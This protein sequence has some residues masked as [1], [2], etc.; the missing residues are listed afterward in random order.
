M[1]TLSLRSFAE[2]AA[3]YRAAGLLGTF[4]LPAGQKFPPPVGFTGEDGR[5]PTNEEIAAWSG[6]AGD[7]FNLGLRLPE[8][9]IGIDVD[10][11]D[12][13]PGGDTL[14][15]AEARWGALPPPYVSS[16]RSDGVSGIRLYRIPTGLDW[17]NVFGP[18]IDT[19]RHGHRY[20]VASPSINPKTGTAYRWMAPNGSAVAVPDLAQV[21]DLPQEWVTGLTG[22]KVAGGRRARSTVDVDAWLGNLPDGDPCVDVTEVLDRARLALAAGGSRYEAMRDA[23]MALIFRG[24]AGCP[25][26][27]QG[28]HALQGEY[29][30]AIAG[31]SERDPHEWMRSLRGAVEKTAGTEILDWEVCTLVFMEQAKALRFIPPEEPS[32][33]DER[34][35]LRHLFDFARGRRVA[36]LAVLGVALA[37]IVAATPSNIVLPPTI[38]GDGSLNLFVAFV[39]ASG[40]GKGT[41]EAAAAEAIDLSGLTDRVSGEPVRTVNVGSGEGFVHQFVT[42]KAGEMHRLRDSVLFNVPEVDTLTALGNRQ[43]ATLM[44][45]LRS[46]WSGEQLGFSYADPTKALDVPARSYRCAL[47]LGVQPAKAGPLLEDADGGT[48]QRFLWVPVIDPDM[49]R[50]R[51]K[52]PEPIV[53]DRKFPTVPRYEMAVCEEAI[54]AIDEAHWLRSRG[55]GDPLDGHKLYCRLKVA[56]ALALLDKRL[57][58]TADDWRLSGRIMAQSDATRAGVQRTLREQA[59]E[60]N[61]GRAKAEAAR[62][63]V[64]AEEVD[65]QVVRKASQSVKT[66]LSKRP[67]EWMSAGELRRAV[68]SRVRGNLDDALAALELSGDIE[69]EATEYHGQSGTRYR[70]RG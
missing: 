50:E 10:A 14:A 17:P 41:S 68:S 4:L 58:V 53:W 8:D 19:I 24:H 32:I 36:P 20:V 7:H 61:I 21:P 48:P 59:S 5:W 56:A 31:E 66:A 46:A 45:V 30:D 54:D 33:W 2:H 13:K 44:P 43:G 49:P 18:G 39:G 22:G 52:A 11:Y 35:I 67:G 1:S 3:A 27:A 70:L 37:R 51:T 42:R 28:L 25:G 69:A 62:A 60:A 63:V 29:E 47:M 38:G 26:V 65:A 34:P 16:A 55:E 23:T 64:V 40:Q 12:G 57:D 6:Q 15:D 9:L